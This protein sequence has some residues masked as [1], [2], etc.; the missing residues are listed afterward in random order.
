MGSTQW[1]SRLTASHW[2]RPP[3]IGTVR[4][5][6]VATGAHRQ[7]LEVQRI[8][9]RISFTRD[10]QYTDTD[11]G[12]LSTIS[13]P[14]TSTI[15]KNR[16]P[17]GSVLFVDDD[18]VTLDGNKLLWLPSDYRPTYAAVHGYKLALGHASGRVIF[19]RFTFTDFAPLPRR[20]QSAVT[21]QL[22]GH[23]DKTGPWRI[24]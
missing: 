4:L 13:D 3:T 8:L 19:L 23:G 21:G 11:R 12:L 9:T 17:V 18:W 22:S 7:P 16:K 14:A 20:Q 6:D 15:S 24:T 5:W 1:Y 10:S 2:R